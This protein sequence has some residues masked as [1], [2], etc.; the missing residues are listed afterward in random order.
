MDII[1]NN[2][3]V[4]SWLVCSC[5]LLDARGRL[6]STREAQEYDEAIATSNSCFLSA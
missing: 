2:I 1:N 5:G 6:L 3:I 4:G